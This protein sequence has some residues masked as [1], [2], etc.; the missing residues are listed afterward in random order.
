MTTTA[1][2]T[3]ASFKSGQEYVH[4]VNV[5]EVN[6]PH[7]VCAASF[8]ITYRDGAYMLEGSFITREEGDAPWCSEYLPREAR[9]VETYRTWSQAKTYAAY[10]RQ[11]SK[12][13]GRVLAA[14]L[15]A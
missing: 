12:H 14:R 8:R 5:H 4:S 3:A 11:K 1:F 9:I 13:C 7:Y 2:P 15:S 10:F 6:G